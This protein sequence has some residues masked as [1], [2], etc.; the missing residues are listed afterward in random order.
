M[1]K[2]ELFE[3]D[4]QPIGRRNTI[5]SHVDLLSGARQ[6][7]VKLAALCGGGGVCGKCKVRLVYGQ[8]SPV[9]PSEASFFTPHELEQ[10]YRLACQAFPQ[11]DVKLHIPAEALEALQR[12]QV[13][14]QE[15]EMTIDPAV[16]AV[17]LETAVP[18]LDDMRSDQFRLRDALAQA[19]YDQL[20]F[21]LAI[22]NSMSDV[23]RKNQW[24]VRLAI[25]GD[26]VAAVLPFGA[27][28]Y[29]LA[30]DIG[31]TKVAAYFVD[32]TTGRTLDKQGAMNPQVAYGE[33]VVS[34]IAFVNESSENKKLMQSQLVD[35]LNQFVAVFCEKQDCL[36]EQ[37]VDAVMVG[38]TAIH[39][40][41]LGLPVEQL[42]MAPYVPA[43]SEALSV[44]SVDIGLEIASGA[45]IYLP[46]NIAGYVGADHVSMLLAT[47]LPDLSGTV[48]A[49]DIGTNTEISLKHNGKMWSCSCASGPAFEGAHIAFGMRAAAGA[50][51]RVQIR[52]GKFLVSTIENTPAVGICGSGIL[53]AVSEMVSAEMVKPLG[54]FDL[55]HPLVSP[56]HRKGEVRL[57]EASSAG[58]DRDIVITRKDI[59]EIQLAKGAIRSGIEILLQTAGIEAQAVDQFILAGAF[60]T[61]IDVDSALNIGMFP[62]LPR[63]RFS[64][65]GNAA[66]MGAK[67]MLVSKAYREKSTRIAGQIE[68][69]ELISFPKFTKIFAKSMYF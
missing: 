47:R 19:G 69:V 24:R 27:P 22:L 1:D 7:G 61:Y 8:L 14:G 3:I 16:V 48:I 31:T 26:E 13:E 55:S 59:N 46:P 45:H 34:R 36:P 20:S 18:S 63:E 33:D 68:Y 42:G 64:Q 52:D 58:L 17:D 44:R 10:G 41:L 30:V 56:N 53:D 38:N 65:V 35:Q 40:L 4:W 37:I 62:D 60:G 66:G 51:E 23:L 21:D 25:R 29:G 43:V 49:C 67:Q 9:T 54:G 50:I 12:L 11:T 28:L 6:A 57:V 39:H 32:L 5:S 2:P 15:A